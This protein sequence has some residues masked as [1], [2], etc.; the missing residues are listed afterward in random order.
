MRTSGLAPLQ[1]L[2]L[3]LGFGLGL[4]FFCFL[5]GDYGVPIA[6]Q[7]AETIKNP[8]LTTSHIYRTETGVWLKA[9]QADSELIVNLHKYNRS[10]TSMHGVRIYQFDP[11]GRIQVVIQAKNAHFEDA[12]TWLLQDLERI[13][14]TYAVSQDPASGPVATANPPIAQNTQAIKTPSEI[15]RERLSSQSWPSPINQTMVESSALRPERM[16]TW[17]LYQQIKHLESSKQNA[18]AYEIEFWRKILYPFSCVVMVV[19]ALPFA[20][21][22]FRSG[23][24]AGFVFIG[25]LIGVSFFLL[26]NMFGYLGYLHQWAP[27]LAAGAPSLIYSV[28]S[29]V[30]FTW[31]VLRH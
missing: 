9:S 7:F 11:Q 13:T 8:S 24:I 14:F 19:L 26:N 12:Q 2:R 20:Y 3:V 23:N 10:K 4:A 25:V 16:N 18:Q 1:A 28:I 22:H 15:T 30:A 6:R 5:L 17:D 21:L 29:L 31:L 27:W